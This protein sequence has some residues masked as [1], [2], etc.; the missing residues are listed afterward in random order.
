[1]KALRLRQAG[2][3]TGTPIAGR[4][5][6][7]LLRQLGKIS[8]VLQLVQEV[9]GLIGAGDLNLASVDLLLGVGNLVLS[10]GGGNLVPQHALLELF[11]QV[12]DNGVPLTPNANAS[13]PGR[14]V[15]GKHE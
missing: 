7:E 12:G 9:A 8:P 2:D 4:V 5:G 10:D 1:M 15:S 11:T 3:R 14:L 6:R 13:A